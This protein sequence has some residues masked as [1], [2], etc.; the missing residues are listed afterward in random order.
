MDIAQRLLQILQVYKDNSELVSSAVKEVQQIGL[1]GQTNL[2]QGLEE[3]KRK[4]IL[5][6]ITLLAPSDVPA[7]VLEIDGVDDAELLV[8]LAKGWLNKALAIYLRQDNVSEALDKACM[9]EFGQGLS[10]YTHSILAAAWDHVELGDEG[11]TELIKP[12]IYECTPSGRQRMEN[13]RLFCRTVYQRTSSKAVRCNVLAFEAS[14]DSHRRFALLTAVVVE[15]T[16]GRV[17]FYHQG[18][19][20]T[21]DEY[22]LDAASLSG[23]EFEISSITDSK[24]R[25]QSWASLAVL[26]SM[27][28]EVHKLADWSGCKL[29]NSIVHRLEWGLKSCKDQIDHLK[30]TKS[31]I[32]IPTITDLKQ[33]HNE[34]DESVRSQL[35]HSF[36][37]KEALL[38]GIM[39][40]SSSEQSG[41]QGGKI[42]VLDCMADRQAIYIWAKIWYQLT[43]SSSF[44]PC[45][46]AM[47]ALPPSLRHIST[48]LWVVPW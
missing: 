29:V 1:G 16:T 41:L 36:K 34:N 33:I 20:Q 30:E 21:S 19:I 40:S 5:K 13:A 8:C 46:S 48:P 17:L 11:L 45:K 15:S 14:R 39:R 4:L 23:L 32:W 27:F 28:T 12:S 22:T 3:R 18:I 44:Y 24:T 9:A 47:R 2:R 38:E 31:T 35:R 43:K 25:E 37:A 26:C 7:K 10:F 6:A 42:W